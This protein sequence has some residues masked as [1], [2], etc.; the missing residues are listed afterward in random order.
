MTAERTLGDLTLLCTAKGH[1][2]VLKLDNGAWCIITHNFDSILIT[3]VIRP[4]YGIKGMPFRCILFEVSKR[5]THAA[6]GCACMRAEWVNFG[7][8]STG[9]TFR[10]FYCCPK[11]CSA[12]TY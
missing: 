2:H 10:Y 8:D 12:C 9:E 3:K 1:S 11:P 5:G 4:F 7:Q 6:L